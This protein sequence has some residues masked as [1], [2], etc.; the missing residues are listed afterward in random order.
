MRIRPPEGL[1][2]TGLLFAL[3]SGQFPQAAALPLFR[4]NQPPH[5]EQ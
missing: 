1:R 4:Q 3:L 5:A 2:R